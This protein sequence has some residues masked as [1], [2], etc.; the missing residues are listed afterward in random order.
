[1][2][3]DKTLK[4]GD[5]V[6]YYKR[7]AEVLIPCLGTAYWTIG[8]RIKYT[9][10]D[11]AGKLE[12]VPT[13]CLRLLAEHETAAGKARAAAERAAAEHSA[14]IAGIRESLIAKAVA[15]VERIVAPGVIDLHAM[16][17][18]DRDVVA[19]S[20][21]VATNI[22]NDAIISEA[23]DRVKEKTKQAKP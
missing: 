23:I 8:T 20:V 13:D 16:S 19:R 9:S 14:K 4:V 1:M 7:E 21:M 15:A 6:A 18:A 2:S 3:N 17:K 12:D 10:G 11:K 5:K 22:L